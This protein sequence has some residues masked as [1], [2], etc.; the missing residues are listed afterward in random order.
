MSA[1]NRSVVLLPDGR[2]RGSTAK[3]AQVEQTLLGEVL[4]E[5]GRAH[6]ARESVCGHQ[7]EHVALGVVVQCGWYVGD[8]GVGVRIGVRIGGVRVGDQRMVRRRQRVS[9]RGGGSRRN[10][11]FDTASAVG[12]LCAALAFALAVCGATVKTLLVAFAV[13]WGVAATTAASTRGTRETGG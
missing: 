3:D 9:A 5:G 12:G 10:E 7:S 13:E 6:K 11:R 4:L 8:G 2:T 1:V